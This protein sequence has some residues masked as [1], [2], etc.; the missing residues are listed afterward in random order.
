[1]KKFIK[2]LSTIDRVLQFELDQIQIKFGR[3]Q[4]ELDRIAAE[5]KE[6]KHKQETERA[7]MTGNTAYGVTFNSYEQWAEQS[8][9][10]MSK[11]IQE[12]GQQIEELHTVLVEKFQ[13]SK[14]IN[15]T[16]SVAKTTLKKQQSQEEQKIL[17]QL[18]ELRFHLNK[19]KEA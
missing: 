2:N 9:H 16:L 4:T 11:N 13:D 3:L 17:D 15:K 8:S 5:L 12:I 10:K 6:H 14:K 7:W 1:M 19:V 18:G